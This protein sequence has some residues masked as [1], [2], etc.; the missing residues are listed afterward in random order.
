VVAEGGVT[1]ATPGAP[2]VFRLY[3]WGSRYSLFKVVY[4]AELDMSFLTAPPHGFEG[5]WE[6]ETKWFKIKVE[7]FEASED[8]DRFAAS[9]GSPTSTTQSS[10]TTTATTPNRIGEP[11]S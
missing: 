11:T 5:V 6:E 3:V 4:P 7:V 1:V 8:P 10:Y 9:S 2:K